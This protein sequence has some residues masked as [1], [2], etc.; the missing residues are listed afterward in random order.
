MAHALQC[1]HYVILWHLAKVSEGSAS[2]VLHTHMH[3]QTC[4]ETV[5]CEHLIT[6]SS[7]FRMI[8]CCCGGRWEPSAWCVR[9]TWIVSA[10]LSKN[11]W[12]WPALPIPCVLSC[13][14]D[15]GKMNSVFLCVAGLHHSLRCT[16]DLQLSDCGVGTGSFRA[17]GVQSWCILTERTTQ[18][19]PWSRV[20]WPGRGQ[21]H[22]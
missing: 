5:I 10:L 21:Q 15:S 9:G 1:T 17:L 11:R 7:R 16:P 14:G 13:I 6:L 18:L 3:A 12:V 20:C 19:H 2:K 4:V 22:R 8:W